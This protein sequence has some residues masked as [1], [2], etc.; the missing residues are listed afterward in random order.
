MVLLL[1]IRQNGN[2]IKN[3]VCNNRYDIL[4]VKIL[5]VM[6]LPTSDKIILVI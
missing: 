6:I 1:N 3:K 5:T 2:T 4:T